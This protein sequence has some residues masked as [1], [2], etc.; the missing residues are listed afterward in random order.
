MMVYSAGI[1]KA[2]N[3]GFE[4]EDWERTIEVNLTGYFFARGKRQRS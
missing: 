4:L 3:H 2:I 1:A